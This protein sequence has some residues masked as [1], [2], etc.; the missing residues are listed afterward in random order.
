MRDIIGNLLIWQN[1]IMMPPKLKQDE[2][3]QI[4]QRA[5]AAANEAMAK[6]LTEDFA[7]QIEKNCH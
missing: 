3:D 1:I 4:V 2:I 7:E 6:Q 5:I